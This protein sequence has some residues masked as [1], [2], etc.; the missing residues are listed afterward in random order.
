[1]FQYYFRIEYSTKLSASTVIA[2]M[3]TLT[4]VSE[5]FCVSKSKYIH[6]F[7]CSLC[8]FRNAF[9][10]IYCCSH[11]VVCFLIFAFVFNSC[12]ARASL[13]GFEPCDLES[14]TGSDS[15]CHSCTKSIKSSAVKQS[16]ALSLSISARAS[17]GNSD[18]SFDICAWNSFRAFSIWIQFWQAFH[19]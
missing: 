4:P 3:Q 12:A 8:V 15:R 19:F 14:A 18:V 2:P 7:C 10:A 6:S 16:A 9:Y 5:S 13:G 1:M 11:S 17:L